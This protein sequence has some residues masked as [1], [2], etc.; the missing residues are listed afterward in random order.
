MAKG[1]DRNKLWPCLS[2]ASVVIEINDARIKSVTKASG[3]Q[4]LFTREDS[5]DAR[6]GS[7]KRPRARI[8]AYIHCCNLCLITLSGPMNSPGYFRRAALFAFRGFTDLPA[9]RKTHAAPYA[10]HYEAFALIFRLPRLIIIHTRSSGCGSVAPA[11]PD[12]P[13]N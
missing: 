4:S 3:T 1:S 12:R 10:A 5:R 6:R 11:R 9:G 8:R 13:E 2:L 7:A